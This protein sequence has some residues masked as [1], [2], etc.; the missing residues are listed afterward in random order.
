MTTRR[1]NVVRFEPTLHRTSATPT[2][3][4]REWIHRK[5][6]G[7]GV[8]DVS[9]TLLAFDRLVRIVANH[10]DVREVFEELVDRVPRQTEASS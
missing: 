10:G 8:R 1:Y 7:R 4:L 5:I 9:A 2:P 6:T 3:V